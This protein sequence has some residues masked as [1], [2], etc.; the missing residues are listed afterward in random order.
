MSSTLDTITSAI[1]QSWD[2]AQPATSEARFRQLLVTL[3]STSAPY[4]ELLTQIARAQGLQRHFAE[5]H[6]TLDQVEAQ[7][8]L[9]P[10]RVRLRYLLERGRVFN[11]AGH[12]H[13]ARPFFLEAWDTARTAGEDLYAVDAAHM[14]GII[15]PPEQQLAWHEKALALAENSVDPRAR[16]WL[17]SLYNNIGW[18]YH[19]LQQDETSLAIFQKALAWRINQGQTAEIRIAKWCVARIL[20]A[21]NRVDEALAI[22]Q[23]LQNEF[24]ASGDADGY[25]QE[26]LGECLLHLQQAE[27]AQPHFAA[28]YQ[29]LA[30]DPWLVANEKARLERLQTLGKVLN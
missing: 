6:E 18:T 5:A 16:K 17:G 25:V 10:P 1:D 3:E 29:L 2:Y 19:D 9:H 22:Q 12:P 4:M 28:A 26:E 15:E 14:L 30:Q 24:E 23:A 11:S 8:A 7:L 27:Q 21:L 13:Q 20:R